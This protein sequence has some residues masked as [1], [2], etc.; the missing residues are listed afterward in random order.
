LIRLFGPGG[1]NLIENL[2]SVL[3]GTVFSPVY[4]A[5][6]IHFA[7]PGMFPV[8]LSGFRSSALR[9]QLSHEFALLPGGHDAT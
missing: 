3:Y 4:P 9:P 6:D 2:L 5:C 7:G 1:Y 8:L